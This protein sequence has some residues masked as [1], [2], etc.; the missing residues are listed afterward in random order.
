VLAALGQGCPPMLQKLLLPDKTL[1]MTLQMG[2]AG[3]KAAHAGGADGV[4]LVVH[5][6]L[7]ILR[8]NPVAGHFITLPL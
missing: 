8:C 6:C 3:Q 7:D 4:E 2:L 5:Q 1:V